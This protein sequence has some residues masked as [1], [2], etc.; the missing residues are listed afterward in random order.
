VQEDLLILSTLLTSVEQVKLDI[1]CSINCLEKLF[2]H[3]PCLRRFQ[4]IVVSD[5][6]NSLILAHDSLFPSIEN[7]FFTWEYIPFRDIITLCKK[8]PNLKQCQFVANDYRY[9]QDVCNSITWYQFIEHDHILLENLAVNMKT[10]PNYDRGRSP[11]HLI[12]DP[13]FHSINFKFEPDHWGDIVLEGNYIKSLKYKKK[14]FLDII[15]K[16]T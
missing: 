2:E 7:I 13:Y 3:L 11:R 4:S 14:D 16:S 15:K 8:M 1:K 6:G 10:Q 5:S 12:G 9:D